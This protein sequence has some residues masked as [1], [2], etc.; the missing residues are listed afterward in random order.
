MTS[1][2]REL[3]HLAI[4]YLNSAGTSNDVEQLKHLAWRFD[5]RLAEAAAELLDRRELV[6][7]QHGEDRAQVAALIDAWH[8]LAE[9]VA[10]TAEDDRDVHPGA[11]AQLTFEDFLEAA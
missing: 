2:E 5:G 7:Q 1:P 4:T 8:A 10:L 9:A 6:I 3:R 11:A